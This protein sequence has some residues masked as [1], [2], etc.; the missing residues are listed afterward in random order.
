MSKRITLPANLFLESQVGDPHTKLRFRLISEDKNRIS[1]WT[2]IFSIDPEFIFVRG[3]GDT[4]G[5]INIEKNVGTVSISWDSVSVY[6]NINGTLTH[7]E[8]SPVYDLWIRWAGTSGTHPS[9]WIYKERLSSTSVSIV[10]PTTYPDPNS[11][12]GDITPKYLY[13]EVYR[14]GKPV[15]RYEY[16]NSFL[17]NAST[18]D[19]SNDTIFFQSGHEYST[20][21]PIVYNSTTPI[22]G[23]TNGS[24]YYVRAVSYTRLSLYPTELDSFNNTSKINL[25][26]ALSGTGT[27]TG[28]PFRMYSGLITT[29]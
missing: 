29:L 19:I 3:T 5:K 13:I 2:P 15:S 4:L 21:S 8:E 1:S 20:G 7:I 26:G 24:T 18:V 25:S 14:Q 22:S 12:Y 27:I 11:P 23:L 10:V 16:V 6:K 17:Q 28:Y 9:D